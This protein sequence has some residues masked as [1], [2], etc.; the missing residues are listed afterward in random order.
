MA[1]ITLHDMHEHRRQ[2]GQEEQGQVVG[3]A[4]QEVA[5]EG[6]A[7]SQHQRNPLAHDVAQ[8]PVDRS[9]HQ[10]GHRKH[11]LQLTKRRRIGP[12]ILREVLKLGTFIKSTI[13][14]IFKKN[15]QQKYFY[16]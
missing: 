8:P 7:E 10:L 13:L 5:E 2:P 6:G 1:S 4:H 15:S 3:D 12:K 11:G 16:C 9:A 14:V